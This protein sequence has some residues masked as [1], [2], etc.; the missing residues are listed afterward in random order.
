MTHTK[1]VRKNSLFLIRKVCD[2]EKAIVS[3][4]LVAV[5]DLDHMELSADRLRADKAA[6]SHDDATLWRR[7]GFGF[8]GN[9]K[10]IE[11]KGAAP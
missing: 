6:D 2:N 11:S 1:R 10:E 4:V 5:R 9:P 7:G 3:Y 8:V